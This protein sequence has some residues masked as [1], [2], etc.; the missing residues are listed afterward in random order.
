MLDAD[1]SRPH[2]RK[3]FG[4][5]SPAL[6]DPTRATDQPRGPITFSSYSEAGMTD[7]YF[8]LIIP[9]NLAPA[10]VTPRLYA[11][12]TTYSPLQHWK[13]G[14]A[15]KVVSVGRGGLGHISVNSPGRLGPAS[16]SSRPPTATRADP[17]GSRQRGLRPAVEERD[18]SPLR[19]RPRFGQVELDR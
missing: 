13:V 5:L 17:H 19:E 18:E 4:H 3:S 2:C 8:A 9:L 16:S 11:G 14:T 7:E 1:L 6:V 10:A 15:K 12:I